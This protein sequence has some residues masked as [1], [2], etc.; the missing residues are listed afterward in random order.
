MQS[1]LWPLNYIGLKSTEACLKVNYFVVVTSFSSLFLLIILSLSVKIHHLQA[2]GFVSLTWFLC[3]LFRLCLYLVIVQTSQ[4]RMS[5]GVLFS[6]AEL[7][8]MK[9]KKKNETGPDESWKNKDFPI[10]K[11]IVWLRRYK[12]SMHCSFLRSIICS[13]GRWVVRSSAWPDCSRKFLSIFWRLEQSFAVLTTSGNFCLLEQLLRK[14]IVWSIG[15]G[16]GIQNKEYCRPYRLKTGS[17]TLL[18]T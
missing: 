8:D 5:I 17:P 12:G 14:N 18:G 1:N 6:F 15:L 16:R 2:G 3:S 9:M 10:C 11:T 4:S 13:F 7:Q